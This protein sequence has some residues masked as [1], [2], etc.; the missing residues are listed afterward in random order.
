MNNITGDGPNFGGAIFDVMNFDK[1]VFLE[2]VKSADPAEI[3]QGIRDTIR[4]V[5]LSILTMGLALARVKAERLFLGL[6]FK[7]MYAYINRLCED[8]KSDRSSIYN[9]INIGETYLKYK[10]ELEMIGFSDKNGPNKL[11]FLE[12]ALQ[13]K[14][15]QEVFANLMD[16]THNEFKDS[17]KQE[18]AEIAGDIPFVEIR[19]N[20]VYI[21]GKKAIIINKN[22]GAKNTKFIIKTIR[23]LCR[24]LERGGVVT[25]VHLRNWK[26]VAL[27][28]PV[29]EQFRKD[30]RG[31]TRYFQ[32]Q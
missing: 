14:D 13:H 32:N 22:L 4:G 25:A 3:D 15:R 19:G 1:T 12:R 29:V 30:I 21:Q 18:N 6:N 23:I 24:A 5:H 9:W 20:T 27:F 17:A 16:M 28:K 31:K 11:V 8:T 10:D 26:E 7:S 2:Y